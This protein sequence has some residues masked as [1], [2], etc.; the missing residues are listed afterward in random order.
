MGVIF[1]I[2]PTPLRIGLAVATVVA[3]YFLLMFIIEDVKTWII[4]KRI[5][6][7]AERRWHIKYTFQTLFGK[8]P[9]LE[10]YLR[11]VRR[12][13]ELGFP[14]VPDIIIKDPTA[15]IEIRRLPPTRW[16]IPQQTQYLSIQQTESLQ[17]LEKPPLLPQHSEQEEQATWSGGGEKLSSDLKPIFEMIKRFVNELSVEETHALFR[18]MAR[19]KGYGMLPKEYVAM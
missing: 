14:Y 12:A 8:Y 19:L 5:R 4:A 7:A 1:A 9:W 16:M 13:E 15:E 10:T 11:E 18:I 2:P 17:P 3:W 6:K